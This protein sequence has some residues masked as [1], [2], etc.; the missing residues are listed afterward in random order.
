MNVDTRVAGFSNDEGAHARLTV[1]AL[2]EIAETDE[3]NNRA[4]ATAERP[5]R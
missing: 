5:R 2:N 3:E 4:A 1:D